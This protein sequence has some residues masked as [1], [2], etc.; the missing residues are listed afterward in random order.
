MASWSVVLRS[1][2]RWVSSLIQ[3]LQKLIRSLLQFVD[4]IN[5]KQAS[6]KM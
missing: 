5:A 4:I 2:Q 3:W 6:S 1:S